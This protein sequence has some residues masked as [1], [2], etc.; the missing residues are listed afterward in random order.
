MYT[1]DPYPWHVDW[2]KREQITAIGELCAAGTAVQARQVLAPVLKEN[3]TPVLTSR[4]YTLS[5]YP[6]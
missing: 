3:F 1:Y 5:V 2:T 6:I 4:E